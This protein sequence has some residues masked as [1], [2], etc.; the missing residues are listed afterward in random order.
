MYLFCFHAFDFHIFM[1]ESTPA[2]GITNSTMD[3]NDNVRAQRSAVVTVLVDAGLR[4]RSCQSRL[5]CGDPG[6]QLVADAV[7]AARDERSPGSYF[8]NSGWWGFQ[9]MLPS[10]ALSRA[11]VSRATSDSSPRQWCSR[12]TSSNSWPMCSTSPLCPAAASTAA[13]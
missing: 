10:T 12:P 1:S 7:D 11:E 8:V 4:A 13:T 6:D 2:Y 5:Q 3:S 9:T